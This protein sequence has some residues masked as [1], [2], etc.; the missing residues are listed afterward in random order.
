MSK[1]ESNC[2]QGGHEPPTAPVPVPVIR[3]N[4]VYRP[5]QLRRTLGLAKNTFGREARL[6]RLRVAKRGGK[7]FVL[8]SW[9]LEWIQQGEVTRDTKRAPSANGNDGQAAC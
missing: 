6:G 3:P 2:S 5:E 9:L 8:G 1:E 4:A 7:V